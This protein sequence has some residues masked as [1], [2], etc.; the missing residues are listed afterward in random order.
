MAVDN[1]RRM[2]PLSSWPRWS[3]RSERWNAVRSWSAS[4]SASASAE[5]LS[6]AK[7]VRCSRVVN[8]S[9]STSCCGHTPVTD[10]AL[11]RSPLMAWPKIV[12][13]PS[14]SLLSESSTPVSTLIAV[15]LPAP[16]WPRSEKISDAWRSKRKSST[17]TCVPKTLRRPW[18]R[19]VSAPLRWS[20]STTIAEGA[21]A[22]RSLSSSSAPAASDLGQQSRNG[23]YQGFRAPISEG[24]TCDRY[25]ARTHD[26]TMDANIMAMICSSLR[27]L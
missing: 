18:T 26:A 3:P 24:Q 7:N 1:L 10:R 23:K 8:F 25:H 20:G 11:S 19:T 12:A 5:P 15:V 14:G 4:T 27:P 21:S 22:S 2:P 13:P 16:L 9:K 17:A 6:R